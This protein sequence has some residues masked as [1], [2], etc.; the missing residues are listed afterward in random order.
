MEEISEYKVEINNIV[1]KLGNKLYTIP[2]LNLLQK[3]L[4]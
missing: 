2:S 1:K 3:S 4:Q